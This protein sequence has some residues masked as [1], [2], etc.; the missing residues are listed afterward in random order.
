[1]IDPADPANFAAKLAG[2]TFLLQEV[3][4]DAVVPNIATDQLGQ[5]SGLSPATAE[6]ATSPTP[7]PSPAITGDPAWVRYP[8]LPPD[9]GTSFPGNTFVHSSL[10]RPANDGN[11]GRLG[12]IRLQTDAIGF[13]ILTVKN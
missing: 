6:A 5:L 3:V 9:A 13:L 4:D 7:T 8:T 11:D 1:V 12:T 10:L 2:R